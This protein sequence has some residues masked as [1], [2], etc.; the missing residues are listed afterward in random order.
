MA[1][2]E[3]SKRLQLP[4]ILERPRAPAD[5]QL[6]ATLGQSGIDVDLRD[7]LANEADMRGHRG[8]ET[9]V[10][11][12]LKL[13][14]VKRRLSKPFD[15]IATLIRGLTYGEMIDLSEALWKNRPNGSAV[16]LENLPEMLHRWSTSHLAAA[17]N[18]APDG[19]VLR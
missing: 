13:Q 5:F 18:G 7:S 2:G 3:F 14:K 9:N 15:E 11:V 6:G 4:R 1:K 12:N 10:A 19:S 16:T 17:H 8:S